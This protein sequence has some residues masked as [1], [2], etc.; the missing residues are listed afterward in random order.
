MDNLYV[1]LDQH[2]DQLQALQHDIDSTPTNSPEF[3]NTIRWLVLSTVL[4]VRCMYDWFDER[5]WPMQFCAWAARNLFELEIWTR[6][7][8]RKRKYAER[9]A[10]DWIMD[11]IGIFESLQRWS[12]S[13]GQPRD[14]G[15]DKELAKLYSMRDVE[16]PGC[17]RFLDPPRLRRR[18]R[19]RAELQAPQPGSLEARPPDIL[20][21]ALEAGV[22]RQDPYARLHHHHRAYV[23]R[24]HRK[25]STAPPRDPRHGTGRVMAPT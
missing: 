11:G 19:N 16:L 2:G 20:V 18:T 9:F 1:L 12:E 14:P 4:Y 23:I 15:M 25:R 21:S 6:Y 22:A 8:L 17:R 13:R 7:V 3:R 5:K 10:K 24:P